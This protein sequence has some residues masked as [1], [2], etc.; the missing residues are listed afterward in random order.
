MANLQHVHSKYDVVGRD[1]RI[2]GSCNTHTLRD[3]LPAA[4]GKLKILVGPDDI[5]IPAVPAM[6]VFRMSKV[7]SPV[8]CHTKTVGWH[9]TC[10]M[11]ARENKAL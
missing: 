8:L 5:R 11:R 3:C 10:N 1:Y 6:D 2:C 4:I 7:P 9:Q